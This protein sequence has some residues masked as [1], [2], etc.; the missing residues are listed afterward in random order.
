MSKEIN[1]FFSIA[2]FI[3]TLLG[4]T[5]EVI[6]HDLANLEH[7]IVKINN[8][9]ISGRDVGDP[10]TDFALNIIQNY[11]DNKFFE[12][13]YIGKTRCGKNM[14]SSSYFIKDENKKLIGLLCINT[15]LDDYLNFRNFLD[16]FLLPNVKIENKSLENFGQSITEV[17][18]NTLNNAI[19]KVCIDVHKATTSEKIAIINIVNQNGLF[20][21]KG[22]VSTTAIKLDISEPTVYRYIKNVKH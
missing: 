9:D 7:S 21:L 16:S 3:S 1:D 8:G 20:L 4:K 13:T 22:S 14:R 10:I 18:E 11:S 5:S 2:D 15:P 6:V 19:S 17:I 12:S